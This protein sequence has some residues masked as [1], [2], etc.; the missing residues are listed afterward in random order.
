[1]AASDLL[2]EE[3]AA[4][5]GRDEEDGIVRD[6]GSRFGVAVVR[7]CSST[8]ASKLDGC[9]LKTARK[10][11]SMSAQWQEGYRYTAHLLLRRWSSLD[12][13]E[14]GPCANIL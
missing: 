3:P 14:L 10:S 11:R 2:G 4:L 6:F 1:M 13:C 5:L 12:L 8:V 9:S 7:F